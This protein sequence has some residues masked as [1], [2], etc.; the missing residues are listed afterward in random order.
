MDSSKLKLAGL[1]AV[2]VAAIAFAV[3]QLGGGG[4]D[5]PKTA[6]YFDVE[7]GE[8]FVDE[9]EKQVPFS[10]GEDGAEAVKAHVY[11]C[12]SCYPDWQPPSPDKGH[13]LPSADQWYLA[14]VEKPR[15][16]ALNA[17]DLASNPQH[18][19]VSVDG[20]KKWFSKVH[21]QE[22]KAIACRRCGSRDKLERL[23]P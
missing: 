4:H 11:T 1:L 12:K 20:G 3:M 8:V 2:V 6:Y 15:P 21:L 23:T 7:A 18:W 10:R 13:V 14:Y 5:I 17:P 22:E 16:D 19:L 9:Y